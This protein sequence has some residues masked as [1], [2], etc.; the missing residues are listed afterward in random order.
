MFERYVLK[1]ND[2]V[3]RRLP[4]AF[5]AIAVVT[6]TCIPTLIVMYSH[7]TVAAA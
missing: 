5:A 6:L 2:K 7:H 3:A 1:Q 4:S